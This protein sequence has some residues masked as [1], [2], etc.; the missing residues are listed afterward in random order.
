MIL[1]KISLRLLVK[2]LSGNRIISQLLNQSQILQ[3]L[4]TSQQKK[5]TKIIEL[6]IEM[7]KLKVLLTTLKEVFS[8]FLEEWKDRKIIIMRTKWLGSLKR[9]SSC[10]SPDSNWLLMFSSVIQTI[11]SHEEFEGFLIVLV[12]ACPSKN[13]KNLH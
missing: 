4:P 10:L 6:S 12:S 3:D 9:K 8:N 2:V 11:N 13:L 1:T 7:K 5:V